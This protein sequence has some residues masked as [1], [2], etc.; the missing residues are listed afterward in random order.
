VKYRGKRVRP[1]APLI[2]IR[3]LKSGKFVPFMKTA[4]GLIMSGE[5]R[6][7][8]DEAEADIEFVLEIFGPAR[9]YL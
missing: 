9:V 2:G 8:R 1:D 6:N 3:K 4:D 7:T 5:P